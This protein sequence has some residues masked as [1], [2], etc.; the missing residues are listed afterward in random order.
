MQAGR[1]PSEGLRR[2]P[3]GVAIGTLS[4]PN[5]PKGRF[6]GWLVF[7][8]FGVMLEAGFYDFLTPYV[9]ERVFWIF[10]LTPFNLYPSDLFLFPLTVIFALLAGFSY[11]KIRISNRGSLLFV[12]W[13]VCLLATIVGFSN[14]TPYLS[15]DIRNYLVRSIVAPAIFV[16]AVRSNLE[17]VLDGFF[18]LSVVLAVVLLVRR[19]ALIL[20][21]GFLSVPFGG[22]LTHVLLLPLAI[23][24]MRILVQE[25]DSA[26]GRFQLI[27]MSAGIIQEFWK[28]T[29]FGLFALFAI[30]F[31][32]SASQRGSA[33]LALNESSGL[34]RIAGLLTLI[35]ILVAPLLLSD[36]DFYLSKF[37][38]A[39]LKEGFAI[40]DLSGNRFQIWA[41]AIDLWRNN[42]ILGTGFG[43][44]LQGYVLH[45]GSGQYLFY[46][47]IYVH[48][49]AL[50]LLY[51]CGILGFLV[52][53]ILVF[54]WYFLVQKTIWRV[55]LGSRGIYLGL[56]VT[57]VVTFV[58]LLIGEALRYPPAGFI[59]WAV[60]G[61][62]AAMASQVAASVSETHP[63]RQGAWR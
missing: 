45:A 28:P 53:M 39:Y 25:D 63:S 46:N 9:S 48:N 44:L 38:Y 15:A 17:R 57:C 60:L 58:I 43:E 52:A 35:G 4:R 20:G 49:I 5:D 21:V 23:T 55:P 19:V 14:D 34:K 54:R 51:Q 2:W 40:Q 22:W 33:P 27:I 16:L 59:F 6:D 26:K 56:V 47:Q 61:L 50:Q 31:L 29:M 36:L 10:K 13:S 18:S 41:Q 3:K 32:V 30:A 12:W 1:F 42:P 24:L 37:R 8:L 11:R 62:E 7:I